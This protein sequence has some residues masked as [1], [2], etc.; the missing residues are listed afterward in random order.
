MKEGLFIFLVASVL[1][2][3]SSQTGENAKALRQKLFVTDQYDKK[4]R[5][6][7]D[8]T[9]PTGKTLILRLCNWYLM[10]L[11]NFQYS[12]ENKPF[13]AFLEIASECQTIWIVI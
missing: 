11:G 10:K 3:A 13:K 12:F 1:E 2:V 4:V 8:Q 7:K 5:S 6:A 9:N